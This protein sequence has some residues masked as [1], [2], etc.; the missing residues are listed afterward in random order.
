[1]QVARDWSEK[2]SDI[3]GPSNLPIPEK[4]DEERMYSR[5]GVQLLAIQAGR[6]ID[7]PI[8]PFRGLALRD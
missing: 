8:N 5:K 3:F 2:G 6:R 1:M 4:L 7:P